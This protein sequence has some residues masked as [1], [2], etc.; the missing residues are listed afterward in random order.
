MT[1]VS[2]G[3]VHAVRRGRKTTEQQTAGA[4]EPAVL[5]SVPWGRREECGYMTARGADAEM[6][7]IH[8]R[9]WLQVD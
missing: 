9:Q 3:A 2:A 8:G 7:G 5:E 6:A 1:A 4:H